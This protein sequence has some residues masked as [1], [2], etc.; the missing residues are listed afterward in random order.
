MYIHTHVNTYTVHTNVYARL[1]SFLIVLL[2]LGDVPYNA[3]TKLI[4]K[5]S[6]ARYECGH[7]NLQRGEE[8]IGNRGG[9]GGGE[10]G[11]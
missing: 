6:K 3:D 11:D 8:G 5:L 10:G 1:Y 4:L 2:R 7:Y 9:E